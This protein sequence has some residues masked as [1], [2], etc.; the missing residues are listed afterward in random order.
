MFG[1]TSGTLLLEDTS[2]SCSLEGP[3]SPEPAQGGTAASAAASWDEDG[4]AGGKERELRDDETESPEFSYTSA[5]TNTYRFGGRNKCV[6][7]AREP[8]SKVTKSPGF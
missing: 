3:V 7:S 5:P 4:E 2:A 1:I 6:P 8:N